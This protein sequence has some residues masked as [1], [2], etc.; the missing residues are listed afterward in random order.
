MLGRKRK[1][2]YLQVENRPAIYSKGQGEEYEVLVSS[3]NMNYKVQ[4]R[5]GRKQTAWV[6]TMRTKSWFIRY[7][8]K[9]KHG[10][11]NHHLVSLRSEAVQNDD[12]VK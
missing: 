1:Q 4:H 5:K 6:K 3:Q 7:D 9:Q 8:G 2:W 12:K 11:L 10:L